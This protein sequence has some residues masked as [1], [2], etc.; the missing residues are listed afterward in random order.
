MRRTFSSKPEVHPQANQYERIFGQFYMGPS[1][2]RL[3]FGLFR[4]IGPKFSPLA[5]VIFLAEK[6]GTPIQ[7]SHS[8]LGMAAIQICSIFFAEENCKTTKRY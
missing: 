5:K 8:V 3:W 2:F 4:K 1:A 7:L 6:A